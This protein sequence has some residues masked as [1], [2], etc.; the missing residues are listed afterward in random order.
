MG[1]GSGA[2]GLTE[3]VLAGPCRSH[4]NGYR[5][6]KIIRD[7]SFLW[8]GAE[9]QMPMIPEPVFDALAYWLG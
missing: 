9:H 5:Q 8:A 3:R 1:A 2:G 7:D 6:I 4:S